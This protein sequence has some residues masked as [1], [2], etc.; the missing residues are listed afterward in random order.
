MQF[1]AAMAAKGI[2]LPTKGGTRCMEPQDYIPWCPHW[3]TYFGN[4]LVESQGS[5]SSCTSSSD[6]RN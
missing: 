6:V 3:R 1:A 5:D 4:D 2:S